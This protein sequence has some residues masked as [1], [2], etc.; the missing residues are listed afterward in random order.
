MNRE[1]I[2]IA[3]LSFG[4]AL[5]LTLFILWVQGIRD[6][7]PKYKRRL[8]VVG[9][10]QDTIECLRT[11]YRAAGSIEGTLL[12]A[13]RKCQQKKARRRFRAAVSYLKESR[14]QD[15]ET[16]LLVYAS[17]GSQDCDTLFTYLIEL[18]VQ[19]TRG[20]PVK[21]SEKEHYEET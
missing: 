1:L 9:Y 11:A 6:V 3:G 13:S 12:L 10:R 5:F 20:L 17:D 2:A 7:V 16:A 8:P 21:R 15:Y 18:E 19:K 14:Y 4:F